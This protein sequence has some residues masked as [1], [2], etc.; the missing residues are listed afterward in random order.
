MDS[1]SLPRFD[2][3]NADNGFAEWNNSYL[4]VIDSVEKIN[5]EFSLPLK[6]RTVLLIVCIKGTLELGYD[7]TSVKLVSRSI[8]VLLPGHLIRKYSPSDDF[9][10]FMISS[11]ISN[12]ANMLPMMSR[13]LVC[14]LHYK[15]NPT[16]LLDEEEFLNQVLFRDLLKHKLSRSCDH[17]DYLVINKLC[18][19]IFCETLND[20]SKR[21]HGAVN[22]QCSRGDALFYRFIVE[23]ENNF[24]QE[25]SV[26]YYAD[27]LC[28]SP[29]H[30]SAVVKDI[31]GRTAGEWIDYY[32]VNEIKRLLTSTDLSIQEISCKLNFVNQSFFGKYFKSHAGLSPRDFRNKSF[33][34]GI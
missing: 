27:R 4:T 32:V 19:G 30:L 7:V 25:R 2:I 1:N 31:S 20:Y 3:L 18:E 17:F 11:A 23:V 29:K 5:A 10:G 34:A 22:A 33:V 28:V 13:I 26:G 9:E 16:I 15:E 12:L 24:K 6:N 21:I 14:S 8:M